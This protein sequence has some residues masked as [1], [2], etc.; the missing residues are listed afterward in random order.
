VLSKSNGVLS[1]VDL[2]S[3]T[4]WRVSVRLSVMEGLDHTS[5]ALGRLRAR[6]EGLVRAILDGDGVT[7]PEARRE[8]FDGTPA[9]PMIG[10]YVALVR[11]HAYRITDGD[12]AALRAT[13]LGEDAV[14]ELTAAAALGA[15]MQR[16]RAGLALLEMKT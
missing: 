7:T 8:A 9:D 5:D 6:T 13:G 10:R 3:L 1:P 14:F 2:A 15:G 4:G 11:R 12:V 16:L